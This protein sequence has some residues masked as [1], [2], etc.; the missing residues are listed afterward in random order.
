MNFLV[1]EE[2]AVRGADIH[3]E[4]IVARHHN[5]GVMA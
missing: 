4:N 2:S 3:D 1:I 5:F